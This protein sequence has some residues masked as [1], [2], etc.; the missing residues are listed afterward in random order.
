MTFRDKRKSCLAILHLW[1]VAAY[2]LSPQIVPVMISDSGGK[3]ANEI[4]ASG[5]FQQGNRALF[6]HELET[7][8]H[9]FRE[10]LESASDNSQRAA[11]HQNLG[12]IFFLSADFQK[13]AIHFEY[14]FHLLESGHSWSNRLAEL[15]LNMGFTCL[16]LEDPV[17]AREWF[18]RA[19]R[20]ALTGSVSWNIRLA[21]GIGNVHFSLGNFQEAITSY[22]GEVSNEDSG[23]S[24]HEEE[25]WLRK[26][27]AWALQLKGRHD[28][29]MLVLEQLIEK[30]TTRGNDG[31]R[32][33]PEILLQKAILLRETGN[34]PEAMG[35]LETALEFLPETGTDLPVTGSA[36]ADLSSTNLL[37]YRIRAEM[38]RLKWPVMFSETVNKRFREYYIEVCDLLDLGEQLLRN[39]EI[40]EL[41]ALDPG[42]QRSLSGTALAL[43]LHSGRPDWQKLSD[44]NDLAER[45]TGFE[46]DCFRNFRIEPELPDES[47][48]SE[49]LMLKK[50]LYRLHRLQILEK[51]NSFPGD[52]SK[53]AIGIATL[54]RLD[55]LERLPGTGRTYASSH[56]SVSCPPGELPDAQKLCSLLQPDEAMIRYLVCDTILFIFTFTSDTCIVLERRWGHLVREQ[57]GE[58]QASLKGLCPGDFTGAGAGLYKTLIGP[59]EGFVENVKKLHIFPDRYLAELPF[60]VLLIPA[61]SSE[62]KDT[63][64]MIER[65]EI[66]VHSSLSEWPARRKTSEAGVKPLFFEYEL[67]ACAPEFSGGMSAPLPH[68]L[69]EVERIASLFRSR[70]KS[71]ATLTGNELNEESFLRLASRTR[72][73]HLATHGFSDPVHPEFSGWELPGD[74]GPSP[75][76]GREERRLEIGAMQSIRLC[77]DLLVMSACAVNQGAGRRGYRFTKFPDNFFEAGIKNILFSM[78]EVSDRH[79][80]QL[81]YS[82]YNHYLDGMSYQGALRA[83]K[84]GML[85]VP[86]TS[87]PTMWAAFVLWEN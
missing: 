58:C 41:V 23:P 87:F 42:I 62:L 17:R 57:T 19:G 63:M 64:Y 55:S 30:I 16:E 79:T 56:P 20:S 86:E 51:A 32:H 39:R 22:A 66:S 15:C 67:G 77:N 21:L 34:I 10:A 44:M 72:I 65:Y 46:Q 27:L 33:I 18:Y 31:L 12:S 3:P 49:I 36:P 4:R 70:G 2:A 61:K 9:A 48:H 11:I 45:L 26:N 76:A 69:M 60:D 78:W 80:A 38:I 53:A 71:V 84:L 6:D 75:T 24:V 37:R 13:A 54:S 74:P 40:R 73:L 68:A 47:V 85:S 52:S 5:L 43:L 83:A 14:A 35:E 29:A 28:S 1:S 7:A 82:F 25:I 59:V 50:Q 8:S 81:M